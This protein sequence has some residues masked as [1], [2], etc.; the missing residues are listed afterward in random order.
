MKLGKGEERSHHTDIGDEVAG[1]GPVDTP[2]PFTPRLAIVASVHAG[3]AL[4]TGLGLSS[5]P[6]RPS[7]L[8]TEMQRRQI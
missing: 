4:A 3:G 5:G 6:E 1:E 2:S 8:S 7:T